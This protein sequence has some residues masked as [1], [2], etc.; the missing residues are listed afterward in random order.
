MGFRYQPRSVR[1]RPGTGFMS[2]ANKD[3]FTSTLCEKCKNPLTP[4]ALAYSTKHY[5]KALCYIHQPRKENNG[6]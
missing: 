1:N 2:Y 3:R 4:A 6:G 5:H